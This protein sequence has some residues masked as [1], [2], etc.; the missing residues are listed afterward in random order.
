MPFILQLS[1]NILLRKSR[2]LII[3]NKFNFK[4]PEEYIFCFASYMDLYHNKNISNHEYANS[5]I[6][7]KSVYLRGIIKN[8]T[9]NCIDQACPC[10]ASSHFYDFEKNDYFNSG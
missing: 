10:K 4:T 3:F 1:R 9:I 5:E 8:H 2:N 6:L 7:K